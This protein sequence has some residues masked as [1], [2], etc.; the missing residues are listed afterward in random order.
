MCIQRP[1]KESIGLYI[2]SGCAAIIL[3]VRLA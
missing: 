3:L 1:T 2:A